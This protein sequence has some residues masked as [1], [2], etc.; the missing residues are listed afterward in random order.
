MKKSQY[1]SKK[2]LTGG[3]LVM[4]ATASIHAQPFMQAGTAQPPLPKPAAAKPSPVAS[5]NAVED[6]FNGKIAL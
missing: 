4:A 6:F 5:T 3:A 1:H 2:I